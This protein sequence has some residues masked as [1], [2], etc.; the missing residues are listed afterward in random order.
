MEGAAGGNST[1]PD[2]ASQPSLGRGLG[3]QLFPL[4]CNLVAEFA[5]ETFHLALNHLGTLKAQMPGPQVS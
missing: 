3:E 5:V 1:E 4:S 2:P